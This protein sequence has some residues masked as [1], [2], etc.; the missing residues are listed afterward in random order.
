MVTGCRNAVVTGCRN[1]VVTGGAGHAGCRAG[2][3]VGLRHRVN[4]RPLPCFTHIDLAVVVGIAR[5][6]EC[7]VGRVRVAHLDP[8]QRAEPGVGHA[9]GVMDHLSDRRHAGEILGLHDR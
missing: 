3:N 5:A 9:D 1:A 6:H 7:Q 8:G 2:V 4:R